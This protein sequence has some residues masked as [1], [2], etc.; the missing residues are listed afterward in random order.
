ML[1]SR[2]PTHQLCTGP[3][4]VTEKGLEEAIGEVRCTVSHEKKSNPEISIQNVL[5]L[6]FAMIGL[7]RYTRHTRSMFIQSG[8][9]LLLVWFFA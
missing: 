2:P 3:F 6:V 4:G 8:R 7:H 1:Q 5:A 9:V